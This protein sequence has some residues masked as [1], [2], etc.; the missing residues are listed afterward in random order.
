MKKKQGFDKLSPNGGWHKTDI[1]GAEHK[2]G[3]GGRKPD[4]APAATRPSG[5][6]SEEIARPEGRAETRK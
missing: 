5:R 2:N 4:R 1:R 6:M 3:P